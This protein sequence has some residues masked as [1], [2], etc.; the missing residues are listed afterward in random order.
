MWVKWL[1]NYANGY[2]VVWFTGQRDLVAMRRGLWL[3]LFMHIL[4]SG[5]GGSPRRQVKSLNIL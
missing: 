5:V 3:I 4:I 2:L 1:N